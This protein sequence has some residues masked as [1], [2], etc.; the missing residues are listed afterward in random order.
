MT[1]TLQNK[2]NDVILQLINDIKKKR[3]NPSKSKTF[4]QR[5]TNFVEANKGEFSM[6]VYKVTI[7]YP[8]QTSDESWETLPEK[9]NQIL[10]T[11]ENTN[12][13]LAFIIIGTE[14]HRNSR[15]KNDNLNV[16]SENK[17]TKTIAGNCHLHLYLAFYNDFLCP[18]ANKIYTHLVKHLGKTVVD[19]QV[20]EIQH[21]QENVNWVKY[22]VKEGIDHNLQKLVNIASDGQLTT[23]VNIYNYLESLKE[24]LDNLVTTLNSYQVSTSITHKFRYINIKP[25]PYTDDEQTRMTWFFSVK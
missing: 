24:S 18:E 16:K 25:I 6:K 7:L 12:L 5:F 1:N 21:I 9:Y 14:M 19:M 20:K 10:H 8:F 3:I 22:C 4:S 11:I 15:G 17:K 2:Q 13:T 23:S